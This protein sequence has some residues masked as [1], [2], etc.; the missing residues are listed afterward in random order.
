M[1]KGNE[2]VT[3]R[4]RPNARWDGDILDLFVEQLVFLLRFRKTKKP[5]YFSV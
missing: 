3:F 2:I 1:I 5:F 4:E